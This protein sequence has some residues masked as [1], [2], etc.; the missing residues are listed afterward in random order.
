[1]EEYVKTM[2][3]IGNV[4]KAERY[5]TALRSFIL[6]LHTTERMPGEFDSTALQGYENH[7]HNRGLCPNT[8]SFYLRNLRAM[9]RE[10]VK[11]KVCKETHP[12]EQVYTGIDTTT[13]RAVSE[14]VIKKI[15]AIDLSKKHAQSFARDMFLFS[16]YTRGMSFVDMAYLRKSDL[17]QDLLTYRR[18]KTKRLLSIRWE[19]PMQEIVSRYNDDTSPYMLPIIKDPHGDTRKQYKTMEHAVNRSLKK[20]GK[21]LKLDIPLTT[22]VARHSWASIACSKDV[23]VETISKALGHESERTTRIYLADLGHNAI[24]HANRLVLS[25]FMSTTTHSPMQIPVSPSPERAKEI[26]V[27]TSESGRIRRIITAPTRFF[28]KFYSRFC[29]HLGIFV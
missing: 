18:K 17:R 28:A 9:Y 14:T 24:D 2:R 29:T 8:C 16:F 26:P 19:P 20:L 22:Y 13:K 1:M 7:L 5:A 10:A 3:Q 11:R 6:Y 15:L 23:S 21:T 27:K 4:C 25:E 12:F